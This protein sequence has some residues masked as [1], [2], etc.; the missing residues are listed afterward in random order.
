M[1]GNKAKPIAQGYNQQERIDYD[2]TFVLIVRLEAIWLLLAF[3]TYKGFIL[4][5]M[6]VKS[7]FLNGFISEEVYVKQSSGFENETFPYHVFKLSKALYSLKQA[8]RAWYKRLSSFLLKNGFKRGKVDTTLFIMHEKDDF[9]I[10][11]IYVDDF[12]FG[13]ANQNMCKSFSEILQGEF[14]MSMMGEL[15][16][17]LGL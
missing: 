2:E 6:D 11:Q 10:V 12:V 3:A 8:P 1:I 17:F 4:S 9:L 14:K 7:A 5:Q 16:Y 13:A 15:K